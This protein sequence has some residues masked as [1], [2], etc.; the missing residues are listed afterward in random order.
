MCAVLIDGTVRK[1]PI[2]SVSVDIL[3]Y[4]SELEAMCMKAPI[5]DLVIGYIP[6]NQGLKEPDKDA[7]SEEVAAV[8]MRAQETCE[9]Q[10][11][12]P[13][14]EAKSDIPDAN[15]QVLKEAQ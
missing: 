13:L 4:K 11:I 3:Y 7:N 10:T 9:T 15:A 14:M 12:K 8:T 6:G 1:F 2:A 5:Y